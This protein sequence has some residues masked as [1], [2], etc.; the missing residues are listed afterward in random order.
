MPIEERITIEE[1]RELNLLDAINILWRMKYLILVITILVGIYGFYRSYSRPKMYKAVCKILPS[2]SSKVASTAGFGELAGIF[3]ANSTGQMVI[4]I[5]KGESVIDEVIDKFHLMEKSSTDIRTRIRKGI[6][7]SIDAVEDS[8]SGGVTNIGY[9]STDPV[10]AAD[11]ANALVEALQRKLQ[12]IGIEDAQ[13]RR[14]FF[15][16]QLRQAEEELTEAEEAIINY[17]Q[18]KGLVAFETQTQNLL[19][20]MNSLRNQIA[21]K[22]VEIST[23]RSYASRDNPRLRLA[24]SQLEAMTKELRRLEEQQQSESNI[25]STDTSG[26]LL[27]SVGQLPEMGI[28]YQHYVRTLR[29]ATAKY[30]TMLRQYESAKLGEVN[31]L[32]TIFIL[33][34]ASV[35]DEEE[36]PRRLRASLLI[37]VAGGILGV[38]AAFLAAHI[39]ALMKMREERDEE[40]Y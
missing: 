36:N 18:R 38:A 23:M 15:E 28:E 37:T 11:M 21:A 39:Q 30:E 25:R 2:G 20:A 22:N 32:S 1:D 40:D 17:Q 12:N 5:L 7:G 33:D 35:P 27:S 24:Q 29:F 31:D 10:F 14:S 16:I 19:S 4:S 26:D 8:R 6:L 34:R 3:G 9:R 13:Q